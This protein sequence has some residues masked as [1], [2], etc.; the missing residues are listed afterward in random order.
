MRPRRELGTDVT[1]KI[2]G[3]VPR[4]PPCTSPVCDGDVY[5]DSNLWVSRGASA[6]PGLGLKQLGCHSGVSPF[7][8]SFP[9]SLSYMQGL[10]SLA[11]PASAC[12]GLDY[13]HTPPCSAVGHRCQGLN[14]GPHAGNAEPLLISQVYLLGPVC[15]HLF[16]RPWE[17]GQIAFAWF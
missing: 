11:P 5:R 2:K 17:A 1:P 9:F 6:V 12:P 14:T 8:L 15:G 4:S 3:G 16:Q 10:V 7:F 13:K